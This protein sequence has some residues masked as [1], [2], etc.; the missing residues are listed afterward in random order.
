MFKLTDGPLK[1]LLLG[2]VHGDEPEGYTFAENFLRKGDWKGFVGKVALYVV[3]RLN[4]DGCLANI[5]QNANGVDLNRNMPTLDWT[6]K[7]ANDRYIPGS[8]PGSE[9]ETQVLIKIIEQEKFS[10][11]ISFHSYDPMI[12]FNGPSKELAEAIAAKCNYKVADDIG[13][14]TPGSLGTWAG[15]ERKI[16]TITYE[17][18]RGMDHD[19]SWAMH[20]PAVV[21]GLQYLAAKAGE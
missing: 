9:P 1:V 7:A 8:E 13:Y 18:E 20:G 21:A 5:R 15:A 3:P 17:I 14:P 16:P 12:N 10:A 2:G 11:I 6:S 19:A 4:P